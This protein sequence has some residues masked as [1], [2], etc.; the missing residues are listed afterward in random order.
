[1]SELENCPICHRPY[2]HERRKF[3]NMHTDMEMCLP[4]DNQFT[5]A[6]NNYRKW[7]LKIGGEQKK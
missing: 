1:M 4:C 6:Q 7:N 2:S 3:T 5:E